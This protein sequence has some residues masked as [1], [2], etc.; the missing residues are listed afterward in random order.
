METET[1]VPIVAMISCSLISSTSL[2]EGKHLGFALME[3]S[4]LVSAAVPVNIH[5][6]NTSTVF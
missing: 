3:I 2:R 1:V 6:M 5:Q 4:C